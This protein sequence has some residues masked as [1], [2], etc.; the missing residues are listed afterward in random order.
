MTRLC[1]PEINILSTYSPNNPLGVDEER[2]STY[3]KT[4]RDYQL[5][6]ISSITPTASQASHR[7]IRPLLTRNQAHKRLVHLERS[8]RC[9]IRI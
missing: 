3:P 7:F 2:R 5:L 9:L 6:S 8:P 4:H 1:S